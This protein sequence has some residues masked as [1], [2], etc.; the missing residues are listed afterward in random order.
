MLISLILAEIVLASQSYKDF[1]TAL[2]N[3]GPIVIVAIFA[4]NLATTSDKRSPTIE[5]F[6][7]F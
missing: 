1:Q 3:Y 5:D 4:S 6:Q 7:E 2:A